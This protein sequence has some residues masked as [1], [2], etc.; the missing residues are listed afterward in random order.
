MRTASSTQ[1]KVLGASL[2]AVLVVAAAGI[3]FASGSDATSWKPTD[4]YKLLNFVL[5][6]VI[7]FL[8]A[9]KPISQSLNDR[10]KN[11]RE[12]LS[13]LEK[14]KEEA[15]KTLDEKN[16]KIAMLDKEADRIIGEYKKQGEAM[17]TK[18]LENARESAAKIEEQA[19][20]NIEHEFAAAKQRLRQDIFE[21]AVV[22]A[23]EL[24]KEKITAEDQDRLVDE[25]LEKVVQQ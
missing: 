13:S 1:K 6:V 15:Q 4:W 24:V 7:L 14:K 12:E 22:R 10:I 2:A 21:K 5:L 23:E 25:Y 9:R 18:I 17:K 20:R 3:S 11:I 16:E 19:Q 8:V